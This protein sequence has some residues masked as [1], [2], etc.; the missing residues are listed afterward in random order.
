MMTTYSAYQIILLLLLFSWIVPLVTIWVRYDGLPHSQEAFFAVL[1]YPL[2]FIDD[3]LLHFELYADYSFLI[4]LFRFIPVFM[5]ALLFLAIRKIV[6]ESPN[7]KL[8][9][10]FP[11]GA[12]ILEIPFLL[13]PSEVK[14]Q[15][16]Q[17]PLVGNIGA[18]WPLF[19]YFVLNSFFVL[20][21]TFKSERLVSDHQHYLSDQVVDINFYQMPFLGKMLN[22]V[23]SLAFGSVLVIM[24]VAFDWLPFDYWL[25]TLTVLQLLMNGILLMMILEKRRYSPSPLNHKILEKHHFSDEELRTT[26]A[27]AEQAIIEHR[28]YKHIGL[29]IRHLSNVAKVEPDM[30][31]VATR[32]LLKRNFRAFIYHYRL[33]YAKKVLMRTD[34]KVSA[35]AKRLGFNSEKFLS[36]VFVRYIGTMADKVD[37]PGPDLPG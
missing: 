29:R 13:L 8:V 31:A 11:L 23:I 20:W 33:E 17:S 27:K 37:D 16:L 30:L 14:V 18:N 34:A 1:I 21:L 19:G 25:S 28:A 32:V 22:A 3:V 6:E 15:I 12:L 4:G 35:V 26:L 36:D 5:A 10:L 2:L 24:F 7:G 9:L